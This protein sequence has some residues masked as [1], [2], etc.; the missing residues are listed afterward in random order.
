MKPFWKMKKWFKIED[1]FK[2][3][4]TIGLGGY[5][6]C[7]GDPFEKILCMISLGDSRV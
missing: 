2:W 3:A 6:D 4:M 1:D 5:G 7:I